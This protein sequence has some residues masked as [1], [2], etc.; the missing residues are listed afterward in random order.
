MTGISLIIAKLTG[1]FSAYGL[2]GAG[3]LIAFAMIIYQLKQNRSKDMQLEAVRKE[4]AKTVALWAERLTKLHEKQNA[5][6]S[7]LNE[8][9]VDDLKELVGD[10]NEIANSMVSSLDKMAQA[11]KPRKSGQKSEKQP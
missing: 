2:L 6:I 10:Y 4:H 7:D 8:K 9:R 11:I 5:I 1:I 3:W